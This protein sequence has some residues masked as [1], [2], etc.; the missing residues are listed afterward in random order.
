[1]IDPSIETELRAVLDDVPPVNHAFG[2]GSGVLPQPRDADGSPSASGRSDN[3]AAKGSVVD[4]VFAVD[5]PYEWHRA[6]MRLNPSH[7][8]PHL[9]TL[10][11]WAVA[12]LADGVGA[13]VHYN[14]L[15]PWTKSSSSPGSSGFAPEMFKYGVVS[16]NSMCDDLTN[17]RHMF[18]AGR[19]QKPVATLGA[20]DPRV[21]AAQATN[22]NAALAAALLFLPEK[23]T[24]RDLAAKLCGLSYTGDVRVMFGAEALDKV[25]RIAAGSEVGLMEMYRD[26]REEIGLGLAG[27]TSGRGGEVWHQDI[28][29]G[30]RS[31]LFATLPRE[32]LHRTMVIHLPPD[33]LRV[34]RGTPIGEVG[35]VRLPDSDDMRGESAE[36]LV[37]F[38]D[39][40]GRSAVESLRECIAWTVRNSSARQLVAGALATSPSKSVRYVASKLFKSAASRSR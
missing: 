27:L 30:A 17:W 22:A 1:M 35:G 8:A 6:N 31:A 24:S 21:T 18:V 37:K 26:A 3:N 25:A 38:E 5:D 15:I 36:M 7:Y 40:G 9:R 23:F 2:Y 32:T 14:T 10:G 13:G 11:G 16:V 29:P 34:E 39:A 4:F 28:R 33:L 19:M 12:A 20:P